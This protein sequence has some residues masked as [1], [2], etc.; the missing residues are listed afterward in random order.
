MPEKSS[1]QSPAV[2][3]P[4]REFG[5]VLRAAGLVIE[6][7]PIMDSQI[8]RVP[9][10]GGRSGAKDGAYSGHASVSAVV[11]N[12]AKYVVASGNDAVNTAPTA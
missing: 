4:C 10:A 12:A 2:L 1:P 6:G 9:V 7:D 5:E 8:H 3:N 11:V